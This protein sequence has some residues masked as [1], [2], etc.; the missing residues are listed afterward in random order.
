MRDMRVKPSNNFSEKL[1]RYFVWGGHK[2]EVTTSGA[3]KA[4]Y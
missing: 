1:K 3:K 4:A 2:K